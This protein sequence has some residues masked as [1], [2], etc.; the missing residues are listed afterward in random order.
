MTQELTIEIGPTQART[1]QRAW[2]G[3][4]SVRCSRRLRSPQSCSLK[5]SSRWRGPVASC[6]RVQSVMIHADDL[7]LRRARRWLTLSR[8]QPSP[9]ASCRRF[10]PWRGSLTGS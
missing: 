6:A 8:T 10:R 2:G 3:R 1:L 4:G 5:H 9:G 7:A